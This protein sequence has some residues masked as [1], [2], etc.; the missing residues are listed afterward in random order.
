MAL[1]GTETSGKLDFL[2][3]LAGYFREDEGRC[4]GYIRVGGVEGLTLKEI[5]CICG[6]VVQED[7]LENHLSPYEVVENSAKLRLN[8]LTSEERK[9]RIQQAISIMRLNKISRTKISDLASIYG[10]SVELQLRRRIMIATEMV[11]DC[12]IMVLEDPLF[13]M[14]YEQMVDVV[15]ALKEVCKTGKIVIMTAEQ[16]PLD[17]VK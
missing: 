6:F 2:R 8:Y 14:Q 9:E 1:L 5:R 4:Q 3:L 17:I 13:G 11:R 15:C 12:A 16:P 7:A 10:N